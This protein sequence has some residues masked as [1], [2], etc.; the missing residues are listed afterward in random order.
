MRPI[1][2]GVGLAAVATVLTVLLF[3][4]IFAA[5]PVGREML[6]AI[7]ALVAVAMLFYVSFWLIA[8]LEHK[9]WLEFVKARMWSAVSVGSAASLM[10]V[11]FTAVYREGFETALFYQALLSF[12]TGLGVYILAGPLRSAS[13]RSRS[14]SWFM[15]RLGRR[16]PIKTFM[17]IAVV[18]VMATRSP[19]SAT[20]CTRC[21][22]PIVVALPPL[23]GWPRPPIF[24]SEAT[25]Y[26]PTVQT[27]RAQ[28][29]LATIYV[30]GG[31]YVFLVKPR[32]ASAPSHPVRSRRPPLP[33]RALRAHGR[34][35]RCRR[36][37]HVHEG[38]RLRPRRPA[39]VARV[40]AAHDPRRRGRR[41]RRRRALRRR[42]R[43]TGRRRSGRARHPLDDAGGE[44]AARG[45]RRHGRRHR[46]RP[47]ARAQAKARKRTELSNVELAPGKHLA[48]R[49][50]VP[51][52]HRR[53]GQRRDRGR[54]ATASATKA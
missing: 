7:T 34:P 26:W 51:R 25:G 38:R 31:I 12:G 54:A 44:R 3:R 18:L 6:E 28:I 30:I 49:S 9:R 40:R 35:R 14:S 52:R 53:P 1:L 27:V 2:A 20:R 8:R 5:L 33:R 11:G 47:P 45:R 46:P 13:S 41:R 4:T 19:S 43:R 32:L 24:L 50:G 15:F 17:N 29:V 16:L 10:L 21:R 48:T 22:P 36:R 42:R 37:R 39:I 23:A